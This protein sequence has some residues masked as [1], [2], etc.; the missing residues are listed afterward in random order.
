MT[1]V[2]DPLDDVT[3]YTYSNTQ[4][5]MLTAQTAPRRWAIRATRCSATSTIRRT[6]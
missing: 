2:E 4:P 5:G 3:T 6:G 1:V